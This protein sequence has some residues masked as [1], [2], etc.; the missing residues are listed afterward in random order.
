MLVICCSCK[1]KD[2]R[3]AELK[4][5]AVCTYWII[6][7]RKCDVCIATSN[8]AGMCWHVGFLRSA[9][10]TLEIVF[11]YLR[12]QINRRITFTYPSSS[13]V[14]TYREICDTTSVQYIR[15]FTV[16]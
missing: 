14:M 5:Q 7:R 11:H 6:M 9:R 12:R 4:E 2:I 16:A 15:T 8:I 3:N 1:V 10:A 13:F